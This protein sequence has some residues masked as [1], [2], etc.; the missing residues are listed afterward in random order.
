V[1]REPQQSHAQEGLSSEEE[2]RE[3][4]RRQTH[5]VG[6]QGSKRD[7]VTLRSRTREQVQKAPRRNVHVDPSSEGTLTISWG[8]RRLALRY[9]KLRRRREKKR[10]EYTTSPYERKEARETRPLSLIH[11]NKNRSSS[12][13]SRE[14]TQLSRSNVA[15]SISFALTQE[16]KRTQKKKERRD[17]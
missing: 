11:E 9:N 13:S 4:E 16:N 6:T 3:R 7:S 15:D 14:N 10:E 2:E 5:L 1:R 17:S 8:R 12:N